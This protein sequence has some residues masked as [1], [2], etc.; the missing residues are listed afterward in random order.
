MNITTSIVDIGHGLDEHGVLGV[1]NFAVLAT[2]DTGETCRCDVS[3]IGG[4]YPPPT[5]P[6]TPVMAPIMAPVMEPIME[7]VMEDITE[8]VIGQVL[9]EDGELHEQI[10][11]T[12]VVGQ[13]QIGERQV[14][15][16]QVGERQV[17]EKIV[18]YQGGY[19]EAEL[20]AIAET[21]AVTRDAHTAARSRLETMLAKPFVY[22]P[23]PVHVPT[24]AER[25]QAMSDQID[26]RIAY[27][28]SRYTRFQL[29]YELREAAAKAYKDAG[30]SGTPDEL[31]K[32]FADNKELPY[33][34]ATDLILTQANQLRGAVRALGTLRMDKYLVTDAATIQEAAAAFDTTTA[35]VDA[36]DRSLA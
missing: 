21:V 5:T 3:Q 28:Y 2:A 25:K 36:I 1:L 32:R 13:R 18:G 34:V 6:R 15:E 24:D 7:P 23:P 19:T 20:L 4:E 33:N 14:G 17:G 29:E 26:S 11:G 22:T 31:V 10:I 12:K 9:G 16:R 8:P 30:Y 27:V 35:A